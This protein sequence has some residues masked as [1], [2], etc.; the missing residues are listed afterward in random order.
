VGPFSNN[1]VPKQ[2]TTLLVGTFP[3]NDMNTTANGTTNAA[4][5]LW[6]FSQT[7]FQEFPG[8]MPND[9]RISIWT[10]SYGGRYGPAFTAYFQEQNQKIAN[11]TLTDPSESFILH[12]DTLGII[13]G[14]IDL[15]NQEE[16]Y[17]TYA[18]NNTYGLET[19]NQTIYEQGIEAFNKPGGCKDKIIECREMA[20]KFDPTNQGVNAEVN[21][22]C[23]DAND[24]CGDA[25]EEPYLRYSGRNFYDIA[26]IS[27]GVSHFLRRK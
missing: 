19:V 26:A 27:Q 7:F 3:S 21:A 14:C 1:K 16:T 8:Y 9:N 18:Y 4:R 10:E 5:A 22:A 13:N 12:L 20:A 17:I 24:F 25:L 6:H 15:L 23:R 11:R 2:N